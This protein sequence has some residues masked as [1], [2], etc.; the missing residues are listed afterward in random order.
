[1]LCCDRPA[2]DYTTA[3]AVYIANLVS[4]KRDVLERIGKQGSRELRSLFEMLFLGLAK[5]S[6]NAWKVLS[7]PVFGSRALERVIA[8]FTP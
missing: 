4:Q 3:D 2:V 5:S 8:D 6:L 7:H 1:M